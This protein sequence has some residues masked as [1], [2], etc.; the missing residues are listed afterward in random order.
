M[1]IERV[2]FFSELNSPRTATDKSEVARPLRDVM[3]LVR[4]EVEGQRWPAGDV[5]AV[6]LAWERGRFERVATNHE[7]GRHDRGAGALRYSKRGCRERPRVCGADA[8]EGASSWNGGFG[9]HGA[10]CTAHFPVEGA[11]R[12]RGLL[13]EMDRSMN[14]PTMTCPR[15]RRDW[16]C[17]ELDGEAILYDA[18]F[19][20][21]CRLNETGYFIYRACD[22]ATSVDDIARRLVE[23]YD[24]TPEAAGLDVQTVIAELYEGGLLQSAEDVPA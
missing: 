14:L 4:L 3:G 23:T 16:Y 5:A 20:T 11:G 21:T 8:S 2:A 19:G 7:D 10:A 1:L 9:V 13:V 15:R 6:F 22:G 18:A 24:V 12:L 17:E